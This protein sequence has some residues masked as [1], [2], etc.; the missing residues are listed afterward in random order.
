MIFNR[1]KLLMLLLITVMA[2]NAEENLKVSPFSASLEL[3]TKYMWY[4][5]FCFSCNWRNGSYVGVKK[6]K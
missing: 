5:R 4:S 1:I 6:E 3:S 2:A